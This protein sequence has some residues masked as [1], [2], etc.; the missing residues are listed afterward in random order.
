M[1]R[2]LLRRIFQSVLSLAL[3]SLFVFAIMYGIGDPVAYLLPQ[4]ASQRD[5]AALRHDLGLDQPLYRQYGTFISRL[6]RGDFGYS[7]YSGRP[8]IT[9][10][11][12][13]APATIEL[14]TVALLFS[15]AAGIPLGILCGARPNHWLARLALGGSILGISV[16]T[17]WLGLALMMYFGV[18]LG[19]LPTDGRGETREVGGV[20]W[21]FLTLDGWRHLIL[22]GITLALY[23][24]AMLLRLVRSEMIETLR[25]P[26]I[27]VARSHGL[28]ESSIIGRHA[29]RN[30]LIPIV[31]VVGVQFGQ[32]LAFSV[33]TETIFQWP[34][35][36]KLLIDS[37]Q[38]DRPLVV[39]YLMLTGG[40]FLTI[41]LLVDLTYALID[42]RIRTGPAEA[43]A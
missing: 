16:P 30:T 43:S 13:R 24:I 3:I 25:L 20:P 41:N 36:G 2:F 11:A 12:E 35:L 1:F 5:R 21:S 39:A 42:P 26:F 38:V 19:W 31:T 14:S 29:M 9:L 6:A 34:G 7:Y 22:P 37:V 10:L 40:V 33:V 28:P 32:L 17:F 8:V 15:L 4:T 27:R 18:Y 23:H